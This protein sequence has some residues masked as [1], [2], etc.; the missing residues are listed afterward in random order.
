MQL[1]VDPILDSLLQSAAVL[2][3]IG[4][5]GPTSAAQLPLRQVKVEQKYAD[6]KKTRLSVPRL[7]LST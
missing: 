2:R 6:R 1:E 5:Q 7:L 4:V 3:A